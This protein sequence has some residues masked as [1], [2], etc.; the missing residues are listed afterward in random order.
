[1]YC[2]F[3]INKLLYIPEGCFNTTSTL[4]TNNVSINTVNATTIIMNNK[5]S[6]LS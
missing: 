3:K 5:T 2:R 1:M 4:P 6:N